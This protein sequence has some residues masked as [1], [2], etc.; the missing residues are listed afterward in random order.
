MALNR[1]GALWRP[2]A[3]GSPNT[4]ASGY[5][6]GPGKV[7]IIIVKPDPK[8]KKE[9]SPDLIIMTPDNEDG[10][11]KAGGQSS[12]GDPLFGGG[13]PAGGGVP[14]QEDVPF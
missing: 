4:V 1:V 11:N 5:I 13:A 2:K 9:N 3:G 8:W 10:Y 12:G 14:P 6:L 7:R